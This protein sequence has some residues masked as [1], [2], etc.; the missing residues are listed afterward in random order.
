MNKD[1]S[2]DNFPNSFIDHIVGECVGCEVFSFMDFFSST[3]RFK[4]NPKDQNKMAFICPWGT[5]TYMKIP[6]GLKNFGATFQ[7]AM[8]FTFHDLKHIAETYL[9]DLALRSHKRSDHPSHLRII[10]ERCRYYQI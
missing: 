6:F 10:F 3:T 7:R 2:K 8:S 4:S 9:D 1:F 5:F